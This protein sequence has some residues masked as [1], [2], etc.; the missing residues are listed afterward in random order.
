ME[1]WILPEHSAFTTSEPTFGSSQ[2]SDPCAQ[3][4]EM[5]WVQRV[6]PWPPQHS[7]MSLVALY[8]CA[9]DL[10]HMGDLCFVS[11]GGPT[12]ASLTRPTTWANSA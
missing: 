8:L 11:P 7:A 2:R 6:I 5:K 9:H 12:P 10:Q 4:P 3:I 1:L